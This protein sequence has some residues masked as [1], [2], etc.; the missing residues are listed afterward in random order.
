MMVHA[1][2]LQDAA[3][4]RDAAKSDAWGQEPREC[5]LDGTDGT[6]RIIEIKTAGMPE[7]I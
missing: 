4:S 2:K 1:C 5:S 3:I 6:R 7:I